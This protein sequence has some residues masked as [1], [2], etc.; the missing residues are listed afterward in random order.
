[1]TLVPKA[2]ESLNQSSAQSPL[3]DVA[4]AVPCSAAVKADAG[5]LKFELS[6]G[7]RSQDYKKPNRQTCASCWKEEVAESLKNTLYFLLLLLT[8]FSFFWM[9]DAFHKPCGTL[10]ACKEIHLPHVSQCFLN[11]NFCRNYKER[12]SLYVVNFHPYHNQ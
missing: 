11:E 10:L 2:C 4:P 12:L 6:Q 1:M 3:L 9:S 7:D 8:L 5:A